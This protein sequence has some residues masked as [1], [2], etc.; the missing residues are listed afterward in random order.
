MTRPHAR[1]LVGILAALTILL[2]G[3]SVA[4]RWQDRTVPPEQLPTPSASLQL[5]GPLPEVRVSHAIVRGDTLGALV[6]PYGGDARGIRAAAMPHTD[7]ARL[8]LGRELVFILDPNTDHIMELRYPLSEDE[9]LVMLREGP[10]WTAR[11]DALLYDATPTVRSFAVERTLW[12]AAVEAGLR[13][14]D[15]IAIA[16]VFETDVDFNTEIQA[17]DRVEMVVEELVRADGFQKLGPPLSLRLHRGDK[18]LTATRFQAPDADDAEYWDEEGLNRKGAFLRSPLEFSRV[19]S[20]FSKGR[21]HPVLKKNRPH[22]GVDFGAP[23]GTPVR[24]VAKGRVERAGKA[25]GH[26][27]FVKIKHDGPYQTSYSHLSRINVRQGEHVAQGQII[28]AVGATGLA[29]GP[30]LH[31]QLWVHGKYQDPLRT[32]LPR[33]EQLPAQVMDEY[34][35]WRSKLISILDGEHPVESLRGDVEEQPV[36]DRV[37]GGTVEEGTVE[38]GEGVEGEA[39]APDPTAPGQEAV[40]AEAGTNQ[41]AG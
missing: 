33:N 39:V 14:V 32:D 12:G 28:G 1:L 27:N 23:T 10:T 13:P 35:A 16:R 19:T 17:G 26:G 20:G 34:L 6:R 25:G 24:A 3:L 37:E 29:T 9:T 8:Q 7:L 15:I 11:V 18:V 22:N 5:P 41:G 40:E 31:Y 21:Y 38:G 2:L 36:G 4:Q 30:H